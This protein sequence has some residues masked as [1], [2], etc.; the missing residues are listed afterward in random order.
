[1]RKKI[2]AEDWKMNLTNSKDYGFVVQKHRARRLHYDLRLAMREVLKS[3][4]L[5]HGPSLDPAENDW[6]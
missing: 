5:P 4:A 6:R 2:L 1:M 3:W